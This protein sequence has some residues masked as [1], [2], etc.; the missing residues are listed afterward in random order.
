MDD[1]ITLNINE[2]DEKTKK[3][4]SILEKKE[5]KKLKSSK[6]VKKWLVFLIVGI[7]GLLG[8]ITCILLTFLLPKESLPDLV[9][10]TIPS[11]T[12]SNDIVYSD[13]TGEVLKNND[14]KTAPSYCIQ[15]PNGTDGARPQ[16][17]L[18]Q[19]GVV[20]E[21]IAEAGITRF[22]AVFQNPS[23]AVIGPLRSLR[24]YYLQLDGPFDCTIVHAGG[25][26]DA[27]AAVK[28]GGY[29]DLSESYTYMYR[30]TY[31]NRLWNN[32]FTT[33]A[34]LRK[35]SD[36]NGYSNSN[37]SGFSRLT[38]EESNKARINELAKEKLSITKPA[39]ENTSSLEAKVGAINFRFG[40]IP[41]FNVNY[42]YDLETNTYK[43]S[44]GTGVAHDVYECPNED[45][46]EKNP[47][48]VCELKQMSPSVVIAM[49]AQE[50]RASDNYHEDIKVIGSGDVF[51]F[52]N[53]TVKTGTWNKQAQ[54]EQIRFMD[55][56][57]KEIK[58]APGQTFVSVVPTYGAVEY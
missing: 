48:N 35:F 9:Y 1:K 39:K 8:G 50:G 5:K 31:S 6:V 11:K 16:A 30:G 58:L 47:E 43:R 37:I 41:S 54:N 53:G 51:I 12:S 15:I 18:R 21:A 36:N 46:G 26:A 34:D 3:S 25:P 22:A 38:P 52:Q 19:A 55:S 10:P 42:T 49:V 7:V 4:S 24:V 29:K 56:E 13:L 45:L 17:G 23:S 33:A 28:A 40:N 57:G 44:Y 27:I 32:L 20:F 2:T 14:E